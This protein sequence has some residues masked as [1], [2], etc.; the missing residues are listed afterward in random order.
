MRP[1]TEALRE[2]FESLETDALLGIWAE[3][4]REDWAEELLKAELVSRDVEA[5]QLSALVAR[6]EEVAKES[7]A[8]AEMSGFAV[9][10]RFGALVGTGALG[11]IAGGLFGEAGVVSALAIGGTVYFA[12]LC[13]YIAFL[14]TQPE[15]LRIFVRWLR[16]LIEAFLVLCG[17][18]YCLYWLIG[19]I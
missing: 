17:V 8:Q 12:L 7:A 13:R 11:G 15:E 6:R 9:M 1:N 18:G 5:A 10:G 14:N 19:K 2:R 3:G 16:A 4:G